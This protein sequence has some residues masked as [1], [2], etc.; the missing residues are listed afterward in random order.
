MQAHTLKFVM[1]GDI[2]VGKTQLCKR[3]TKNTY[4]PESS[5]TVGMEFATK[6]I[7]FEKSLIKVY[8]IHNR[9]TSNHT[10]NDNDDDD[11]LRYGT[12]LVKNDSIA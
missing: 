2:N 3:F 12:P 5:S 10:N 6:E 4:M 11:S 9:T 8:I 1:V 7:L